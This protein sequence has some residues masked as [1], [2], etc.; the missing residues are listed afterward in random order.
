[1]RVAL[2]SIGDELLFGE[3]VDT[4]AAF[5]ASRFYDAGASVSRH[6]TVGDAPADIAGAIA[7]LLLHS[8]IIVATGGLGPTEDDCTAEGAA[9]AAGVFLESNPQALALT[10][11]FFLRRGV[12]MHP[13]NAKQAELP[14]GAEIIPNPN[15]TASGF[16]LKIGGASLYFLPGVP[17]EMAS[18]FSA[19]VLPVVLAATFGV[20]GTVTRV[21]KVFGLSEPKSEEAVRSSVSARAGL[22]IAY[23]VNFPEVQVKLR[24]TAADFTSATAMVEEACAEARTGLADHLFAEGAD[25]ME[26]VVARL[27]R[28][29]H[30]TISL[31]ESCT[32]GLIAKRLTDLPGSSDYFLESVVS[33]SNESKTSLIGVPEGLIADLG[34]VSGAVAEKMA[35]GVRRLAGST[36]SLAVTGIAGPAGGTNEKP[37][38]TVFVALADGDGTEVKEFRFAGSRDRIRTITCF[39]AL[40]ML[41]RRLLRR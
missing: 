4:N 29:R 37:V 14:A 34:A 17:D 20:T 28:E 24:A 16:K 26:S 31:A 38:G 5:M 39:A 33:Y 10:R 1:V 30:A 25:T 41:R 36:L 3:I 6:L 35:E 11:D 19:T 22:R 7:D 18:M 12:P 40:D 2:L 23:C 13:A 8:D 27:L 21:L 32:G 9:L 15:G